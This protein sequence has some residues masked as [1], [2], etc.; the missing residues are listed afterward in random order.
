MKIRSNTKKGYE[1]A[2]EGDSINLEQLN[3]KTRR[4]RVGH[5]VAQ[6]LTTS[7]NQAVFRGGKMRIRKLTP[8]ECWRLQGFTDEQFYSAMFLNKQLA[9]EAAKIIP[10]MDISAKT[11]YIKKHQKMSD[12]QLYK[13][14]GNSVSVPVV[15]EIAIRIAI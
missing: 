11:K 3:S 8:L 15:E 12:S 13:Q 2:E 4:G 5:G 7:C 14:A 6:T 10:N 1:I 9:K